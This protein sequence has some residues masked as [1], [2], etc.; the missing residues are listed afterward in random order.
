[1]TLQYD[2]FKLNFTFYVYKCYIIYILFVKIIY[3]NLLYYIR[4]LK[5]IAVIQKAQTK[6]FYF[7]PRIYKIID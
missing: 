2:I 7:F 3:I 5:I 6:I 1:M 4:E